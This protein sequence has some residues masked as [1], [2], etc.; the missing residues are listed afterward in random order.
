MGK[1]GQLLVGK[2]H[3]FA[4]SSLYLWGSGGLQPPIYLGLLKRLSYGIIIA[5]YQLFKSLNVSGNQAFQGRTLMFMQL[6]PI[7]QLR[8]GQG[9]RQ[10]AV[11][12]AEAE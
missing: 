6:A 1:V 3:Y 9:Q 12:G 5:C 2:F 8:E 11:T 7:P 4:S 10:H